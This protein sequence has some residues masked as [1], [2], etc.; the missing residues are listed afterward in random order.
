MMASP[1]IVRQ[2][3]GP[4]GAAELRKRWWGRWAPATVR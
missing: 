4:D 1:V 2:R 3:I